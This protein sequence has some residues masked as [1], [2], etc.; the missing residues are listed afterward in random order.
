[1]SPVDNLVRSVLA[2]VCAAPIDGFLL[3]SECRRARAQGWLS[4]AACLWSALADVCLRR[5]A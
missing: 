3:A 4:A 2:A 1:L 5:A